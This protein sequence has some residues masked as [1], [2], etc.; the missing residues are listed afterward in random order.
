MWDLQIVY[1]GVGVLVSWANEMLGKPE[2][3]LRIM[4]SNFFI[5]HKLSTF[6]APKGLGV[7]GVL[8]ST[9]QKLKM[10]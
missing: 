6:G 9:C 1:I 2:H 4:I 3:Q 7:K 5:Q 10:K 8:K